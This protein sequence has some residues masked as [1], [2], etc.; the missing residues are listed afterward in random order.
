MS[1]HFQTHI[2]SSHVLSIRDDLS[3]IAFREFWQDV[4]QQ[5]LAIAQLQAEQYALWENDSHEFLVLFFAALLA[6]KQVLIAPH[7]VKALEEEL[8]QQGIHFLSRQ[9]ESLLENGTFELQHLDLNEQFLQ[10]AQVYFYTSGSTGQPKKI[11]R[12]LRQ[13]LNEVQGLDQSFDLLQ[14][15]IAIATVSHQHIYGLLFKLL[16]PLASGR[17]FYIPQLA[18]PEDVV[19]VQQKL[20]HLQCKNY[21]ISSPALLKRWTRDVVLQDC[22]S[23][24]SSGGKLESGIRPHL[25]RPVVEVLGSSETGGIAHRQ[26]DDALWTPFANVNIRMAEHEELAVQ[27]NHAFTEDWILTGDRVSVRDATCLKTLFQLSGRLDRLIK[28]EEKRLS[29]DAIEHKILTLDEIAE[30]HVLVTQK[31]HRQILACVAV[32]TAS[33]QHVLMQ[34]NKAQFVAKLKQQLTEQLETIAIPRQWRFLSQLPRNSQS[35]LNKQMMQ[36]LFQPLLTPVVLSQTYTEE[37]AQYLL[38]FPP[39]L[40][41]F[42]GHFPNLPIYAGVGQIGFIQHFAKQL[43]T[44]LDWCNGY[45]QLKFQDLIKPYAV[46]Q[47]KLQRQL[48]KVHFE[49]YTQ[50][51]TLASGRL[52]FMLQQQTD[53]V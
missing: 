39:E 47:L 40:A 4:G 46:V 11:P 32:L 7:R 3:G 10:Q 49:L 36:S 24:Y 1:C 31:D 17:S 20:K 16:L 29:L 19:A 2:F 25:N 12:T 44:A 34:Q 50:D 42:K 30:C 23:V 26:Q 53:T 28:L 27:T 41:C 9:S 6:N 33:A 35:K 5:S 48:H 18:F 51:K 8:A 45:E 13:L 15:S 52:L 38:E 14:D 21:V 37:S 22:Q 43:W